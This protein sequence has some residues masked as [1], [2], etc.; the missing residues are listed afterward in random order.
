MSTDISSNFSTLES[1]IHKLIHLQEEL[2]KANDKLVSDNDQLRTELNEERGKLKRMEEGYKNLKQIEKS[3]TRENITHL[4][5]KINDIIS[6]IDKNMAMM[7][8]KS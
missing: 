1:R 2:K 7:H 6:E 8:V 5:R 4:K 3:S